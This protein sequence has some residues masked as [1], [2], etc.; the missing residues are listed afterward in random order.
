MSMA[1]TSKRA[2]QLLRRNFLDPFYDLRV[3][4]NLSRMIVHDRYKPLASI[5]HFDAA[6]QTIDMIGCART[7]NALRIP[8][9][10]ERRFQTHC[11]ARKSAVSIIRP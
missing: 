6:I 11:E 2:Q 9:L 5:I 4:L 10:N 1:R 8:M 3:E 7:P